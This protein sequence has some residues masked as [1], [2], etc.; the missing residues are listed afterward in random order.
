VAKLKQSVLLT[1]AN[2]FVATQIARYLMKN[3]EVTLFA[4]V[5]ANN[6]EEGARR[7]ARDW[8]DWPELVDAIGDRVKVV[9]GDVCSPRLGLKETDYVS[10]VES[11]THII[12]TA[13]DWRLVSLD[14]IRKTNVQG[15][16]NVL[17]LAKEAN[18]NHHFERFAHISTA[19]V[20]GGR[21]GV[22]SETELTDKFGFFTN[23]ELS[24]YEGELLVQAAK[25]EFPVSIFRPSMVVGDS[26]TGAIKTFNT[27]YYPLKLYLT[28]K[29]RFMPVSRSLRINVVPVDYVAEAVAKLTFDPEAVGQTF[30]LVAP[31]QSLITLKELLEIVQKWARTELCVKLPRPICI[32]MS[33]SLM[34]AVIRLQ[35]VFQR[36]NR[37]I[38]DALSALAPYFSENRQFQRT[39]TDRL[40]G[41]YNPQWKE[42]WPHLL[43]Y[44]AYNSFLHRSDRTVHEQALFRLES[45]SYPVTY[46]DI[47]E[48]QIVKKTAAEMRRDIL[49]AVSA[50]HGFGI[51]EGDRVA[52]TGLNSTRYL[53]V[54]LAIGL[55]GAV[56]VP[57]YYTSPPADINQ[58]LLSSGSKV[59]F[60]GMPSLLV[61]IG[62]LCPDVPVVSLI[63]GPLPQAL[64]RKVDSWEEFL[65][66]GVGTD[67]NVKA[68]VGFGD[69]ATLR[70]SSGTTG[71]PKGA[72][73]NHSNLRYMAEST[74]S[75]TDWHA[76][77]RVS[78]YLS[79]LPMGHVVEGMLA[80]YSTYYVP[81]PVDI[82][83]LEDFRKLQKALPQVKP[84]LFFSVP[85]IYEKIW[86]GLES[87]P[88]GHFYVSTKNGFL[89]RV[90]RRSVRSMILKRAGLDRCAQ[91]IAGSA[92]MDENLLQNFR[93]LGVEIHNAYGMTE[94]PLVTLNRIGRNRLGTVGEPMP[95]TQV[96][97]AE[98]GEIMVKGPQV[99]MGYFDKTIESPFKDGWLMTGDIGEVTSEDS[100]VIF[101]RKKELIKTSYGKCIYCGKIEG[102]LRELPGVTEALL[103]GESKPYCSA[104]L[105]VDKN[106]FNDKTVKAIETAVR[107]MNNNL[108]NPEKVKKWVIHM[109]T[110][111][112]EKGDLTPNLKLKRF[113]V[114]QRFSKT[115]DAL[116]GGDK[117]K[118]EAI[119]GG[120]EKED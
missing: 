120:S 108:S 101:G 95:M 115:V 109:N 97:I 28:G 73:F 41:V 69:T 34:K 39:N 40:L 17:E 82:Y 74:V 79:F 27:L 29:R 24:K 110:L 100:L 36:R 75:I 78:S 1:G 99:T 77:N 76:R 9:C 67:S 103:I 54:D 38:S 13:A 63:R 45:I 118:D 50:L 111:S 96:K 70:Y 31:Y 71:K 88:F 12:H 65:S 105:W 7:L 55:V 85:R 35:R 53:A 2:G 8:W 46:Y 60:V 26:Q 64:S 90:L 87:N 47:V 49:A 89:R 62:E 58:I 22:V 30:H 56:S 114:A 4:L 16:V 61:R 107:E 116:Y 42:I 72:V 52:L 6:V 106:L 33:V 91:L 11:V 81:A 23:Y 59:F 112:I 19:Y 66:K 86:E 117:P 102:M 68:P 25:N 32:P 43:E 5:R 14:E 3:T 84:V 51:K 44:A 21:T 98:D 37:R 48:D 10:L 113:V 18:K 83:F 104:L 80:T 20:A 119:Y 92:R 93:E 94:A 57:L 15:T